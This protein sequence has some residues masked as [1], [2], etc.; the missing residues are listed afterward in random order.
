MASFAGALM[1]ARTDPGPGRRLAGG[2]KLAHVIAEFSEDLFRAASRHTGNR[3]EAVERG[4]HRL[5]GLGDPTIEIANLVFEKLQM[6][7]QVPEQERVV[8]GDAS[9]EYLLQ[10]RAFLP[11]PALRQSGQRHRIALA[12][13]EGL[14]HR[15]PRGAEHVGGDVSKLD[16]GGL[17]HLLY[18][19]GLSTMCLDQLA[20]GAREFTQFTLRSGR[21]KAAT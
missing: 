8:C 13:N 5:R 1:V 9:D 15:P 6:C 21:D 3:V 18:A 7:E 16:V 17:E 2:G 4:R 10:C 14:E 19:I 20:S 11:Q 12:G